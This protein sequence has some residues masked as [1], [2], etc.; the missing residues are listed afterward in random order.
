MN[1]EAASLADAQDISALII[2]LSAPFYISPSREGAEPF[3]ASVSAEA[4]RRYL[5][6]GN[7]RFHLA[8]SNGQLAGVVALR[9][10]SHLF[11]LFVAKAFQGQG[12]A[13]QLWGV[14]RSEA[15][16]AGNPGEFTV[17][18]SLNAVPV[19]EKFGFVRQ[20]EVQRMH[21][22]CFQPMRLGSGRNGA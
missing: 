22:I 11:H 18:A 12:L 16:Q 1:I 9:D 2:E 8:R 21:G 6:A 3:L 5:S 13:R 14:A 20:G 19:Y 7:F 4:E 15:M 10:G 17:N